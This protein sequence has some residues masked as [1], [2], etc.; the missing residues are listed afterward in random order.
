MEVV[1]SPSL[2]VFKSRVDVALRDVVI[3]HRGDG[4]V[5][6]FIG[7]SNLNDS[8]ILCSALTDATQML[9][10]WND[11]SQSRSHLTGNWR[12]SA[13]RKTTWVISILNF[14]S[15]Q[16]GLEKIRKVWVVNE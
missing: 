12:S 6:Q 1:E 8:M 7:L 3:G 10:L 13:Q 5:V 9:K 4:L 16:V 2:E 14:H 11:R 15:S